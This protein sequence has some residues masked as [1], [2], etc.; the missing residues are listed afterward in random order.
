MQEKLKQDFCGNDYWIKENLTYSRPHLRLQKLSKIIN[1]I[2]KNNKLSLLDVGCGPAALKNLLN[3]NIDYYGIDIAIHEPNENFI[4][5]DIIQNTIDFNGKTFDLIISSGFF[6]Y[7]GSFY[8]KKFGEINDILNDSGL[9]ILTF[10]NMNHI[11][12]PKYHSWNNYAS[13]KDIQNELSQHFIIKKQF[14]AYY[15][16]K[17]KEIT[18]KF[19]SQMQKNININ[20]P[21]INTLF[22]VDH[23]F[24]CRKI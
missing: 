1:S 16:L 7:A 18:N 14:P 13:I 23:I 5:K 17:Y 8:S 3:K 10:S 2:A 9:F 22:G 24:I 15:N 11:M 4:E 19:F 20:I 21:I 12:K 6:E